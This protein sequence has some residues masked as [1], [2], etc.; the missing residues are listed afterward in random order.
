MKR[1][2]KKIFDD[3]LKNMLRTKCNEYDY[4]RYMV[5]ENVRRL[6]KTNP[7]AERTIFTAENVRNSPAFKKFIKE[8]PIMIEKWAN[9][10]FDKE[11]SK[12]R[13]ALD[14]TIFIDELGEK[15]NQKELKQ[16]K[17]LFRIDKIHP[18]HIEDEEN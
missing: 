16:F 2:H 11:A 14:K 3:A 12:K 18:I 10:C 5:V 4:P 17:E 1:A 8:L 15:L 7:T 13:K 6:L 9:D